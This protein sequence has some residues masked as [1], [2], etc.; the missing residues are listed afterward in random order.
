MSLRLSGVLCAV[1]CLLSFNVLAVQIDFEDLALPGTG[2]TPR[3]PSYSK[4]GFTIS[5]ANG[6][7]YTHNSDDPGYRGSTAM[8]FGLQGV[9][10]T[11]TA[12]HGG[13][14]T[15]K[16]IDL[17]E[18]NSGN[19]EF[20]FT[21]YLQGGGTVTRYV[22]LDGVY[23]QGPLGS[24]FETFDFT[25]FQNVTSVV[26][27]NSKPFHQF[28]NIVV[29]PI[30]AAVWLFGSGLLGLVGLARRRSAN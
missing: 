18:V 2:S 7:L 20:T 3:G 15:L 1:L 9:D 30:P 16:S 10:G 8:Y 23:T 4:D 25:D 28:D 24:G 27:Q 5:V 29:T 13:A 6:E 22:R 17:A 12:N 11:L 14:F 21:G 19:A 26:W